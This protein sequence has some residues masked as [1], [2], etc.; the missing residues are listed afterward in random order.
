MN[1]SDSKGFT[2]VELLLA[3]AILAGASAVTYM[4]FS[5]G[6]LAW[7]KG[8]ALSDSLSHADFIMEQL[9]M[10]LRSAYFPE[11][12][13]R[14][15]RYG[16]W[17]E[18]NGDGSRSGDE[19]SWVKLGSALVGEECTFLGVP[20]RVRLTIEPDEDGEDAVAVR[21]WRVLGQV[22]DFEPNDVEPIFLSRG[23]TGF[24]CRPRD[25]EDEDYDDAEFEWMDEWEDTNKIPTFVEVSIFM[26]PLDDGEDPVEVK[27]IVEIP[28]APQSRGGRSSDRTERTPAE[29]NPPED[30]PAGDNPL[31]GN[32]PGQ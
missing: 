15:D 8:L 22:E 24:N 16:F 6:I 3:L 10:G 9:V 31:G 1:R 21:A 14:D 7:K 25:P 26:E 28:V 18:D 5:A 12:N 30:G 20:H 19:I 27:R 29:S 32:P 13:S 23:V 11:G 17:L 4:S 2:L